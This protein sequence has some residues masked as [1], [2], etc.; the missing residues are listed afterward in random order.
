MSW[1]TRFLGHICSLLHACHLSILGFFLHL[2]LSAVT[3]WC[4]R[5]PAEIISHS[6]PKQ[7]SSSSPPPSA[8]KEAFCSLTPGAAWWVSRSRHKD[9]YFVQKLTGY[10]LPSGDNKHQP[11]PGYRD[12]VRKHV[13]HPGWIL[14]RELWPVYLGTSQQLCRSHQHSGDCCGSSS[15]ERKDAAQVCLS[16]HQCINLLSR[17]D[18]ISAQ[19]SMCFSLI[20]APS[21]WNGQTLKDLGMLPLHLTSNFYDN[22]DRVGET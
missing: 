11:E 7:I 2:C 6:W 1:E 17:Q 8:T 5:A 16:C 15:A 4:H 19:P 18:W 22:F 13:L 10:L 12:V 14:H 21:T 9:D 3:L 20:R